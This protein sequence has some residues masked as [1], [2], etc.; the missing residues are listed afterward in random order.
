MSTLNLPVGE[1]ILFAAF[2]AVSE[3][4]AAKPTELTAVYEQYFTTI[5]PAP[6]TQSQVF[7]R[8]SLIDPSIKMIVQSSTGAA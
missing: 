7:E 3:K 4:R 8:F 6:A 2:R 5:A 1:S